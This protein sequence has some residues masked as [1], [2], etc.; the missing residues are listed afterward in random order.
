VIVLGP[1]K[2]VEVKVVLKIW[3]LQDF[4]GLFA[5]SSLLRYLDFGI[6]IVFYECSWQKGSLG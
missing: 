2:D 4:E 3:S 5:D 6:L 1:V